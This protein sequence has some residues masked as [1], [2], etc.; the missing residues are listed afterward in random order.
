MGTGTPALLSCAVLRMKGRRGKT[1]AKNNSAGHCQGESLGHTN[2]LSMTA[3]LGSAALH[4]FVS[5]SCHHPAGPTPILSRVTKGLIFVS[6]TLPREFKTIWELELILLLLWEWDWLYSGVGYTCL[7][8]HNALHVTKQFLPSIS[9]AG[10]G[11]LSRC[12]ACQYTQ[13]PGFHPSS[14]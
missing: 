7:Y 5:F 9:W 14:A 10:V 8:P 11:A 12:R 13:S 4:L 3:P 6:G 2:S 1:E